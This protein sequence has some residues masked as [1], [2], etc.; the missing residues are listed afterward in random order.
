LTLINQ[1][2]QVNFF[3]GSNAT[4]VIALLSSSLIFPKICVMTNP[5]LNPIEG[6]RRQT[7]LRIFQKNKTSNFQRGTVSYEQTL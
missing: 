2:A 7:A 3:Y 4:P 6:I 1:A 5:K